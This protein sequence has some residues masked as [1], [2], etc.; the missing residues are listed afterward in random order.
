MKLKAWLLNR[1]SIDILLTVYRNI[2]PYDMTPIEPEPYTWVIAK[3]KEFASIKFYWTGVTTTTDP[4]RLW[5][6]H[7]ERAKFFQ[8]RD[9]ALY[10]F[11]NNAVT[12]ER[13]CEALQIV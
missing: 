11:R 9:T 1:P 8:S 7:L 6:S 5:T 10:V 12:D 3:T 2:L 4:R 13:E